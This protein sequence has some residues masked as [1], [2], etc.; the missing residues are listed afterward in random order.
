MTS[1]TRNLAFTA[2]AV[3]VV[4]LLWWAF[5]EPRDSSH[6]VSTVTPAADPSNEPVVTEAT[7]NHDDEG[8]S[9]A[10]EA[11]SSD[12]AGASVPTNGERRSYA[13]ALHELQGLSADVAPGTQI[14]L[15]VAWDPPIT[16]EPDIRLLLEDVIIEKVIPPAV[17]EGS[18]D[19]VLSVP[20]R[21]ISDLY[22]GDRYGNFH[23]AIIN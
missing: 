10:G 2:G 1:R 11:L 17:P 12:P 20:L 6:A 3:L 9:A 15:W 14:E 23:V 19:V 8:E 18:I 22:Y 4:A 16:E 21:K 13:I 7:P 5:L